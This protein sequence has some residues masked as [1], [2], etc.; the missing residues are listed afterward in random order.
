MT[1]PVMQIRHDPS[2]RWWVAAKW[3]QGQTEDIMGF[4]TETEANDWIAK[5]LDE[6]LERRKD[7]KDK[8][9]A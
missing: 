1:V 2:D 3:P 5:E 6:W 9:D 7:R 8:P 4:R